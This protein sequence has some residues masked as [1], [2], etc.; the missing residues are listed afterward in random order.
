MRMSEPRTKIVPAKVPRGQGKLIVYHVA[1][2]STLLNLLE[3]VHMAPEDVTNGQHSCGQW[4]NAV[5][6][7]RDGFRTTKGELRHQ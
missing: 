5:T 2:E 3:L 6:V 4:G 7:N 1:H